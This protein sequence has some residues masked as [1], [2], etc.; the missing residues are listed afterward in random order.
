MVSIKTEPS[1]QTLTLF[2]FLFNLFPRTRP[3]ALGRTYRTDGP[4]LLVHGLAVP[5]SFKVNLGR[6]RSGPDLDVQ[7]CKVL[8][9]LPAKPASVFCCIR[10]NCPVLHGLI[11]AS[12]FPTI[13]TRPDWM[14]PWPQPQPSSL[15]PSS[16]WRY[17]QTGR[18]VIC[19]C[20]RYYAPGLST[21]HVFRRS[22]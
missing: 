1:E 10:V 9:G 11:R 5:S 21:R 22:R 12:W 14:R 3:T 6:S 13:R 19:S 15:L 17:R 4:R 2:L 7:G 20:V 8:L 16:P 18:L